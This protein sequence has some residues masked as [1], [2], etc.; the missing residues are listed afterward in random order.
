M[1]I[2]ITLSNGFR[3]LAPRLQSLIL[4]EAFEFLKMR[5]GSNGYTVIDIDGLKVVFLVSGS[6][7]YLRLVNEN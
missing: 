7:A 6:N 2:E 1:E 5:A 4:Q 3:R